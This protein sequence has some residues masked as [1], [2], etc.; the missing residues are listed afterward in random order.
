VLGQQRVQLG[1]AVQT[2]GE[3]TAGQSDAVLVE[4][5]DVVVVLRPVVTD[6]DHVGSDL[7]SCP[8]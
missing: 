3:A 8:V 1:D 2:L 7:L 4:D 5:L 6:E